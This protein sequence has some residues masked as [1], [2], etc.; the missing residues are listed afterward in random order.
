MEEA[1][2][3]TLTTP[4]PALPS[5]RNIGSETPLVE[6]AR[7]I[8]ARNE[9]SRW[10]CVT[11]YKPELAGAWKLVTC[12]YLVFQLE[13]TKT[14]KLHLQGY[15]ELDKPIRFAGVKKLLGDPA[16]HVRQR[17]HDRAHARNYCMKEESRVSPPVEIG[18]WVP[19]A[20]GSR[21]DVLAFV[22][23]IRAGHTDIELL[24]QYPTGV[25]RYYRAIPT[26][27][28]IVAAAR[29]P[30]RRVVKVVVLWG[31]SD[32]GKTYACTLRDGKDFDDYHFLNV[33]DTGTWFDGYQGQ[34][35]LI[36]D[37]FKGGIKRSHLNRYLD[38]YRFDAQT[39][40]S[41]VPAEWT[42]VYITSNDDP[43]T[44]YNYNFVSWK[45][46]YRRFS[47]ELLVTGEDWEHCEER[48]LAL[49]NTGFKKQRLSDKLMGKVFFP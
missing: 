4:S 44:W 8:P 34:S 48:D 30:R 26:I 15:I 17:W 10:W 47:M 13:V 25:L 32:V 20:Q 33:S 24:D 37:E 31:D 9:P 5:P 21:T 46:M 28:H 19:D 41:F 49:E 45:A 23:A 43:V 29:V 16:L 27:R 36:I 11:C 6:S 35:R 18:E 14:E 7:A 42:E 1:D 39:K 2:S 22:E 38:G 3:T 40:G 12:K